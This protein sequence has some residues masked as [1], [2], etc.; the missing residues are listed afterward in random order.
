MS[1]DD[2]DSTEL[3]LGSCLR[4]G[5]RRRDLSQRELA[6]RAGVSPSTVARLEAGIGSEGVRLTTVSSIFTAL[7]L[8]LVCL[9]AGTG[10]EVTAH[11]SQTWRD[12]AGRR[13]PP[14]LEPRATAGPDDEWWWGWLRFSTWVA[15]PIPL[16]SYFRNRRTRDL[17]RR[18]VD[19]WRER[20]GAQPPA[21]SDAASQSSSNDATSSSSSRRRASSSVTST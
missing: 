4:A 10:Q 14:H 21:T 16:H 20:A 12:A 2:R 9:D 6:E 7:G 17:F 11:V 1:L 18:H 19:P 5:R 13:L 15:P 8:R 3:D